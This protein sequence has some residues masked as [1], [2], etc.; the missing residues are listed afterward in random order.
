MLLFKTRSFKHLWLR[1]RRVIIIHT[2]K[3]GV[4]YKYTYIFWNLDIYFRHQSTFVP[5]LFE[6]KKINIYNVISTLTL[7]FKLIIRRDSKRV[8]L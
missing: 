5:I 1:L 3:C 4:Y 7:Q 2:H 8:Y 6:I